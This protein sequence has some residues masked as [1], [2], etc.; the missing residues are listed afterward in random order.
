MRHQM[1]RSRGSRWPGLVG[2]PSMA[3]SGGFDRP[4][5]KTSVRGQLSVFPAIASD[6][7]PCVEGSVRLCHG[8][9]G[10]RYVGSW[11]G[12]RL[13]CLQLRCKHSKECQSHMPSHDS[14]S[15]GSIT[16]LCQG[17]HRRCSRTAER[18]HTQADWPKLE[19]QCV[20]WRLPNPS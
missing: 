14:L 10:C 15:L 16:H 12:H 5:G 18:S 7:H 6:L 9:F 2:G 20:G 13:P 8:R 3:G 17:R 19:S 1:A 11:C 4:D